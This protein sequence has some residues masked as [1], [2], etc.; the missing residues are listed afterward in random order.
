ML[1]YVRVRDDQRHRR[2]TIRD[3]IEVLCEYAGFREDDQA[4]IRIGLL[5]IPSGDIVGLLD[6]VFYAQVDIAF[7]V[8]LP[9]STT[10][11]GKQLGSSTYDEL[12]TIQ[13]NA[14]TL[15]SSGDVLLTDG[16]R[17]RAVE[18]VPAKLPYEISELEKRLVD[19]VI[20]MLGAE[21]LCYRHPGASVFPELAK[22]ARERK[23]IDCSTLSG[24][25][26]PALK[27]IHW[28]FMQHNSDVESLSMQTLSNA[29]SK[30]GMHRPIRRPR[31]AAI[32]RQESL[33]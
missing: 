3:A 15:D 24:L 27:R 22:L 10:F 19:H 29:L 17:L 16:T 1:T 31:A 28:D 30:Y 14:A 25:T 26:I 32:P 2:R 12:D 6:I 33:P 20:A 18:V 5:R 23:L 9:T 21:D 4:I 7:I 8:S 11:R 13:L